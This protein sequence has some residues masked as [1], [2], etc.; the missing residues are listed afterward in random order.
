VPHYADVPD[1]DTE[2]LHGVRVTRPL[3]TIV[4]VFCAGNVPISTFSNALREGL[5]RG[6]IRRNEVS[7]TQ[8]ELRDDK[9]TIQFLRNAGAGWRT[10]NIRTATRGA[11]HVEHLR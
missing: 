9:K 2:V 1:K 6:V 11:T 5:H 8:H 4:D 7:A 10:G 3:R